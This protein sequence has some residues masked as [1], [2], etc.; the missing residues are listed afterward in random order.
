[1][2]WAYVQLDGSFHCLRLSLVRND[3]QDFA[4]AE[5][6]F[7]GHRD[8]LSRNF[9]NVFEPTLTELLLATRV[10]KVNDQ[11][12]I[13]DSEVRRRIVKR[14]MPVFPDTDKRNVNRLLR[15]DLT[16]AATF[17]THVISFTID[18]MKCARM[19]AADDA[20]L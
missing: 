11:V 4:A 10:I 6:L 9:G 12:R 17:I 1:M 8:R 5:Y 3:A 14:Q 20:L 7:D 16:K 15:D 19:S 18:N 2:S 13:V